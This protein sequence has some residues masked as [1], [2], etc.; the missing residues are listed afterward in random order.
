MSD[1]FRLTVGAAVAA[2]LGV[3]TTAS[4]G[5]GAAAAGVAALDHAR[6]APLAMG[7]HTLVSGLTLEANIR[8]TLDLERFDILAPGAIV[9]EGTA[10]GDRPMPPSDLV[11]LKG[12]IVGEDDSSTAFVSVGRY[13]VNGF[14]SRDG[15]LYSI[16]SG[17]YAGILGPD[18]PIA[19]TPASD[20]P[21]GGAMNCAWTPDDPKLNPPYADAGL[22][23][24]VSLATPRGGSCA[25]ALIA[26]DTDYEFTA[27][28]FGGNTAA[29]ADYALTL[30]AAVSTVYERDVEVAQ[31]VSYLRVWGSDSD[32]YG[33]GDIGAF[34]D[35]LRIFWGGQ[36]SGVSRTVTHG[37]SGR[38]LGGGV[39]YVNVLCNTGWGYGV[40]T[41]LAGSFP[42]PLADHRGGNWDPFV[43]AHELGH[44]FGTGH[45]H[46]SYDPVI[47]GCG[48]G[49][50]SAAWGGTIMSYCHGCAGGMANIVMAFHPRVQQV[51]EATVAGA[52]CITDIPGGTTAVNDRVETVAGNPITIDALANDIQRSCGMPTFASVQSPTPGGGIVTVVAGTDHNRL[53]Y[54]PAAGYSGDDAFTYSHDNGNTGTVTVGVHALQ[55]ADHPTNPLPGVHVDYYLLSNPTGLPDFETL[56]PLYGDVVPNINF[57]ETNG[58]FATGPF[59][60]TGGA[61][62]EGYVN[63]QFPGLFT[64]ELESDDGSRLLVGDELVI[65]H[66]G[67]HGMQTKRG[68]VGLLPGLHRVRVEY[69]EAFGSA[70]L[71]LRNGFYG[72]T[73]SVV[74][75]SAWFHADAPPCPAD[76]NGDGVVDF[77]DVQSFLNAYASADAAADF[78][79]D[80]SINFFDLQAFL[81][82]Y[83]AGCP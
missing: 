38:G 37:L 40:S 7:E 15:F 71:I 29:A 14:V 52:G 32:P 55:A 73:L 72:T 60:N 3:V 81:N 66:D 59:G 67:L 42:I 35:Q 1:R 83:A 22:P 17:P 6:L 23:E 41:N 56:N 53:R 63:V 51:I 8:V 47:D 79:E 4:V 21:V 46:D 78:N 18:R 75:A 61:V 49:D 65:D 10:D 30:H 28:L 16:S 2:A 20:L 11:L 9:V 82:A 76:L 19:V 24:P 39:A 64:F 12:T 57:P 50:C 5:P 74:P 62:F 26:V 34:L 31:A 68:Y 77:F 13:G 70:G 27:N 25:L 48:N 45:T 44:N 80:G 58:L 69:F 43:V 36:M 54:E 33:T